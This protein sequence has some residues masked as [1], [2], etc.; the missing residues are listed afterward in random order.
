MLRVIA[1]GGVDTECGDAAALWYDLESPTEEEERDVE[2]SLGI[3]VPTP[4]ERS[5]FEESARY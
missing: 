5:A 3:D 1:K 2:A 4:A